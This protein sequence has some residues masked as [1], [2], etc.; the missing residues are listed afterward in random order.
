M[1]SNIE[2]YQPITEKYKKINQE[3]TQGFPDFLEVKIYEWMCALSQ[4]EN[5]GLVSRYID[6][7]DINNESTCF[8][9]ESLEFI[10]D[11]EIS[12]R[13]LFDRYDISYFLN[14]IL[15][16]NVVDVSIVRD[17]M[18]DDFNL[19]IE[20]LNYTIQHVPKKQQQR[21]E[22][23]LQQANHEYKVSGIG[24][25]QVCLTKRVPAEV[26][27]VAEKILSKNDILLGAWNSVYK[28][29][30]DHMEQQKSYEHAIKECCKAIEG[31]I[32]PTY[33]P[34]SKKGTFG[35][36]IADLKDKKDKSFYRGINIDPD[37]TLFDTV[38]EFQKYSN[39]HTGQNAPT[40]EDAEFILH[41]T[42][43]FLYFIEK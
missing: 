3:M 1:S 20:F 29:H 7:S 40:R 14:Q 27:K 37:M 34:Q 43:M 10:D 24:T 4:V 31:Y 19:G 41:T 25:K 23:I 11:F 12:H 15:P 9:F 30:K 16:F 17:K 5:L 26:E 36:L 32:E 35:K 8:Y 38:K 21:F 22:D 42:I 13:F 28:K 6:S 33:F 39:K 2:K 18:R